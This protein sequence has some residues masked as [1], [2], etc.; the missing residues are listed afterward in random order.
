MNILIPTDF[1]DFSKHAINY[2][3][4][5]F[6]L[7]KVNVK[8]IHTIREPHSTSGVLI[9]L[10]QLMM[11]DAEKE[12]TKLVGRIEEVYGVKTEYFIK[13][14]HLK[15]W[16]Y[17]HADFYKTDLIVMGTKGE[18]NVS[19]KIMGSVTES[20]IRSSEVPV[21]AVPEQKESKPVHQFVLA[22]D[23]R[24]LD[25]QDFIETFIDSLKL[26]NPSINI[27]T[28]VRKNRQEGIP[29]SIPLRGFQFGVKT[30]ENESVVQG[31]NSFLENNDVDILGLYHSHNSRLDYLFNRSVT[32]TIC[33]KC[34]VPLLVIPA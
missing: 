1:S 32:R 33:S 2:V 21:L 26:V 4:N 14:G 18:S 19:A 13:Y 3:H 15:D 20:L 8:L 17:Q 27:L 11:K 25:H 10:D 31:I 5:Q 28:V 34:K 12:M 29:K 22:T 23:K 6:D 7:S 9:R 24:E 30:I 16:V